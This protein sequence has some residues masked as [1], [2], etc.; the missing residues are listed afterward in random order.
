MHPC[1][2]DMDSDIYTYVLKLISCCKLKMY[3][4]DF[5]LLKECNE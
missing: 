5:N 2:V 3:Q 1:V 4:S